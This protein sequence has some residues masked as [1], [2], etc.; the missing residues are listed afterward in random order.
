[1]YFVHKQRFLTLNL[2]FQVNKQGELHYI[3]ELLNA[4]RKKALF[5]HQLLNCSE[6]IGEEFSFLFSG[7]VSPGSWHFIHAKCRE[8]I[9]IKFQLILILIL[10]FHSYFPLLSVELLQIQ[11]SLLLSQSPPLPIFFT[12]SHVVLLYQSLLIHELAFF[13]AF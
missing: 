5:W 12:G 13:L 1:M 9:N 6:F 3:L 8:V 7:M 10:V 4:K 2:S 11:T